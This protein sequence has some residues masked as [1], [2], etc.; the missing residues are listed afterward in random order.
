M[1]LPARRVVDLHSTGG[2]SPKRFIVHQ[3]FM[4]YLVRFV[5]I[6]ICGLFCLVNVARAQLVEY[7]V[8]LGIKVG[9]PCAVTVKY[10]VNNRHALEFLGTGWLYA[11]GAAVLYEYHAYFNNAPSLRWYFGGGGH[12]AYAAPGRYNPYSDRHFESNNYAGLDA[13]IGLE[14]V[15][16]KI[17]FSISL[18]VLPAMNIEK[19]VS[20]WWN[21]GISFRYVF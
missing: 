12:C 6:C 10:M 13:V 14:Y 7:K 16:A 18:D 15:F 11:G 4:G 9:S 20:F 8:G 3:K 17:P 1:S 21:A 19:N 2:F 5:I